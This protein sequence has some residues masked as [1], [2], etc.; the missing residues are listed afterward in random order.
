MLKKLKKAHLDFTNS[1]YFH[2][3]G[4]KKR[5]FVAKGTFEIP[6][7]TVSNDNDASEE[8]PRPTAPNMTN[9][10]I[11]VNDNNYHVLNNQQAIYK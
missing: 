4:F 2:L 7:D 11:K 9:E 1:Q 6:E 10:E 8:T 3:I 5:K